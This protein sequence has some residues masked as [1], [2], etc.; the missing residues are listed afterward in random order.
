MATPSR[1]EIWLV[2]F[3][4]TRGHEQAGRRPALIISDD[5]FNRGHS[6]LVFAIPLTTRQR[7]IP[8][9]V[10]VNPPEGGVR[11]ASFV[12]CEDLRSISKDRLL[13]GP[14]G[15]VSLRSIEA[16]EQR[17]RFLLHL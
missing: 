11:S 3:D 5:N 16:V 13:E 1:G 8:S 6:G 12:K 10:P 2:D 4:P 15:T 14:W 17:L 9:H 7:G